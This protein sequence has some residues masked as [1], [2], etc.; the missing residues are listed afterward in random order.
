M[1]MRW[2]RMRAAPKPA[3]DKPA[4]SNQAQPSSGTALG[5]TT[6]GGLLA[7]S[8]LVMATELPVAALMVAGAIVAVPQLKPAGLAGSCWLMVQLAP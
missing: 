4:P 5:V 1:A 6:T 2:R 8:V 3:K 7:V